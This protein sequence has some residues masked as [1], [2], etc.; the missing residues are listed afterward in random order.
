MPESQSASAAKL[1]WVAAPGLHK[2]A[3]SFSQSPN[4]GA[5][6]FD[7]GRVAFGGVE[8][9]FDLQGAAEGCLYNYL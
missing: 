8:N 5:S 4:S 9:R 2:A 1:T 3:C 6:S 7:S